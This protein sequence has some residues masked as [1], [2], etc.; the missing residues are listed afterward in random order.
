MKR[1]HAS[2]SVIVIV[3]A[4]V[5]VAGCAGRPGPVAQQPSSITTPTPPSETTSSATRTI[6]ASKAV[7]PVEP[8][9][10]E[11]AAVIYFMD[12][13]RLVAVDRTVDA[14]AVA[15]SA[16]KALLAG[17]SASETDKGLISSIPA[18]TKLRSIKIDGRTAV[19]DLS[20]KFSSGGGSLSMLSRVAQVVY[21]V[22]QFSS[23]DRVVFRIEGK[24]VEALGG[25]GIILID[26][27][28][29]ADHEDLA[30]VCP[31]E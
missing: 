12:S 18:G 16:L 29:R 28:T 10:N 5:A 3:T 21:T 26:P 9:M 20:K 4:L 15:A 30:P 24:R 7:E 11:A 23:V 1:V 22:T 13:E 2:V 17:P 14:P 6:E 25:E 31:V 8:H 19:V 27:Q